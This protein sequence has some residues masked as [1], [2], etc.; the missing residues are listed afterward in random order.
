ME[1]NIVIDTLLRGFSGSDDFMS[2]V[3]EGMYTLWRF[4]YD[5]KTIP[6]EAIKEMEKDIERINEAAQVDS[7][8]LPYWFK[9]AQE[10]AY[11]IG[12]MIDSKQL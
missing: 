4:L 9:K 3:S 8:L 10:S 11:A 6:P 5:P 1:K 12:R 7:S 2:G